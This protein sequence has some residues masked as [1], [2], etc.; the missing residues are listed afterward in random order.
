M[1][2]R[3]NFLGGLAGIFG[4]GATDAAA[5]STLGTA[6]DAMYDRA[7]DGGKPNV[8][9]DT[10]LPSWVPNEGEPCVVKATGRVVTAF[11]VLVRSD[12]DIEVAVHDPFADHSWMCNLSDL[13]RPIAP[14]ANVSASLLGGKVPPGGV[15]PVVVRLP[16]GWVKVITCQKDG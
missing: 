8:S 3:R 4:I 5:R 15:D 10:A 9:A 13:S 2:N 1:N 7:L 11:R 16:S 14:P 6:H 12:G